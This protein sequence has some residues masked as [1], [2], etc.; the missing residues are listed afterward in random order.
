V[1]VKLDYFSPEAQAAL[2]SAKQ[3]VP[4]GSALTV[5]LL[6]AA[7]YH[8]AGK[9]EELPRLADCL[10]APKQVRAEVPDQV[11]VAPELTPVLGELSRDDMV[12]IEEL[13]AALVR[14]AAGRA[15]LLSQGVAEDELRGVVATLLGH[16]VT[17]IETGAV[18]EPAW[19][20]SSEREAVIDELSTYG[21]MLTAG[22]PPQ[23]GIVVMDR[24]LRGLQKNLI[25]MRRPSIIIIGNPG[26]GKTALV[27][28]LA[29]RIVTGDASVLPA[30]RDRD[31]FELS[32]SFLRS[33]ASVVGQYDE[34]VSSLIKTLE[35]NPKIILFVDE[36]HSLLQSGMH[37]RGPF[38]EANESFKQAIGRGSISMIGA[39]TTAEYRH[40]IAADGAL[41][42]R[43]GLLRIEPPSR[44]DTVKILEARLP[45][46][47]THYPAL[48][49]PDEVLVRTVELTEDL[50]PTR[51]QPD[52]SLEL[53]D[54]ACALCATKDPPTRE[55]TDDILAEALEDSL[56]HTVIRAGTLSV[57]TVLGELRS[58]I[59][60]QEA[61]MDQLATS[62]VAAF[63]EDWQR[64]EGPRGIF[65]FCGPTGVGKTE[66]ALTLAKILG[67]GREALVR[68]DCNTIP[69]AGHEDPGPVIN[70]LLGVPPGY[71][72]YVRGE[73]GLLS[74]VR[75]YTDSIVLFD[76]IE[77][78]HPGVGKILLQILDEGRVYDTDS[79]LLDFRRSFIVFTTNAGCTYESTKVPVG[80]ALPGQFE[81]NAAGEAAPKVSVKA[82]QEEL[83]QR[84]YGEEFLGRNIDYIVFEAMKRDDIEVVLRRQLDGLQQ[85]AELRDL[86]LEY[87]EDVFE[88]LVAEWQP[89]FGV[90]Q[91][92]TILRHRIV[93]QLAIAEVQGELSGVTRIRLE[94]LP[95]TDEGEPAAGLAARRRDGDTMIVYVG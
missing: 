11:P 34:R 59:V 12:T 88:H 10:P 81:A 84:G 49:I 20:V 75:D 89:R 45:Q 90:R 61:A 67:G 95:T 5:E 38:T 43:F 62:F 25:R 60:G 32:P 47:Q 17:E 15:F 50:L 23:K 42:R 14:S 66:T 7:A 73:G 79:N 91:L 78:A 93:E 3:A 44:D 53:L 6:L 40:Y 85:T 82:V 55:L 21:R 35:A 4:E 72:G 74:R 68:V 56:G 19:R 13:M 41:A 77:K 1:P 70:R 28:E 54:E 33:G 80:F 63:S 92:T 30:L 31:V 69:G 48:R 27:Y 76:E 83:R 39:T 37:E 87:G 86:E 71:I 29:R 2:D 57:E 36:V 58:K 9:E 65:F 52:K 18:A 64:H 26:T 16:E 94:K 24:Y 46:F 8:A 51:F 22:D